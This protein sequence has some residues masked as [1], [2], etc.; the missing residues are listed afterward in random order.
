MYRWNFTIQLLPYYLQNI[1]PAGKRT[2]ICFLV[3]ACD[4]VKNTRHARGED[5]RSPGTQLQTGN[6]RVVNTETL[7]VTVRSCS[8]W[9]YITVSQLLLLYLYNLLMWL[10]GLN[11]SLCKQALFQHVVPNCTVLLGVLRRV[12]FSESPHLILKS[13]NQSVSPL[14]TGAHLALSWL[15]LK[16][17]KELGLPQ[18]EVGNW[19]FEVLYVFLLMSSNSLM[20][21]YI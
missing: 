1:L 19:S 18:W 3:D 11:I 2:L 20:F 8:T 7:A 12:C 4:T 13:Q 10:F 14:M 15:A 16:V 9:A 17:R 6:I 5:V 21:V